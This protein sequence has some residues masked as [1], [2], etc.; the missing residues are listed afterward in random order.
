MKSFQPFLLAL[1]LVVFTA[2]N[3]LADTWTSASGKF[4]VEAEFVQ[5][6]DGKVQL[7]RDDTGDLVW[8]EL[9]KLS[10]V[11]Q[12]KAKKLSLAKSKLDS[13]I[14]P[15]ADA[16]KTS[17]LKQLKI[18]HKF[19]YD[20]FVDFDENDK[21][22]PK[23]LNLN[24]Y[25]K[26]APAATAFRCGKIQIKKIESGEGKPIELQDEE[27]G[28]VDSKTELAAIDRQDD[29]FNIHPKDGVAIELTIPAESIPQSI[30]AIQ[31][32]FSILTGGKRTKVKIENIG[33]YYGKAI[34]H[35]ALK[36]AGIKL[37]LEKADESMQGVSFNMAGKLSKITNFMIADPAGKGLDS[38]SGSSSSGSGTS[39][40]RGIFFSETLPDNATLFFEIVE[41]AVEL[42]IPID[43]KNLKVPQE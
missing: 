5:L 38:E 24:I 35:D 37:G 26:G 42:K 43:L 25:A 17:L 36:A 6:K 30:K 11:D 34:E 1:T 23:K 22:L 12:R 40:N 9:E 27:F 15:S 31:G 41:D 3:V 28:M 8:V 13:N 29:F 14:Q 33:Q 2:G 16:G 20:D 18:S 19:K 21:A 7:K 10:D 4:K 39:M 32:S